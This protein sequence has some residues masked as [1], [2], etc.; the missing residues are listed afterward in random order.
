MS[1]TKTSNLPCFPSVCLQAAAFNCTFRVYKS[2]VPLKMMNN[3]HYVAN[4][5]AR[6][7]YAEPRILVLF[8][9]LRLRPVT[10]LTVKLDIW[11]NPT[12]PS[13]TCNLARGLD[14]TT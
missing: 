2:V 13:L 11:S 14:L 5:F 3:N 4:G 9:Y 6:I 10:S 8:L 1:S 7:K 12:S